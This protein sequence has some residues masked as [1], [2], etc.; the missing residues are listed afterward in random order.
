[1]SCSLQLIGAH[2]QLFTLFHLL[3]LA[4]E[5]IMCVVLLTIIVSFLLVLLAVLDGIPEDCMKSKGE[6]RP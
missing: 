4:F 5:A 3:F 2:A 1:M 6:V